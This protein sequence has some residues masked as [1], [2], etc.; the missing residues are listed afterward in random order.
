MYVC[1]H[2]LIFYVY[3]LVGVYMCECV[4]FACLCMFIFICMYACINICKSMTNKC[5]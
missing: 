2:V 1:K 4:F 5:L 3:L